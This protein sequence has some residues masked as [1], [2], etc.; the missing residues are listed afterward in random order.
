MQAFR[1]KYYFSCFAFDVQLDKDI[2]W[3]DLKKREKGVPI[4]AQ[5]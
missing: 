5:R 1:N 3:A 4:V 2:S